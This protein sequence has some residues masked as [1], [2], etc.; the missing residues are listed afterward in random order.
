MRVLHEKGELFL[1][2]GDEFGGKSM[3]TFLEMALRCCEKRKEDRPKMIE[4]AKEIKLIEKSLDVAS[5]KYK[6]KGGK[7][8][9][10]A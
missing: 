10:L 7:K 5:R 3:Y 4:V 8:V 1:E 2:L 9:Y 6:D